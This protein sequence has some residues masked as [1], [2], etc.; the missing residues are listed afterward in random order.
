MNYHQI[1]TSNEEEVFCTTRLP[2]DQPVDDVPSFEVIDSS[3]D[4]LSDQTNSRRF[5]L[6]GLSAA[7]KR[8]GSNTD[9]AED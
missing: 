3:S 9:R 8:V 7:L 1:T 6:F 5:Y 4:E 2:G